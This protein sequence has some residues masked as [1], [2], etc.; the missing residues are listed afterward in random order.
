MSE[1]V[2]TEKIE[3]IF[4]RLDA[5]ILQ[6]QQEGVPLE[7]AFSLYE[8]GMRD[9]KLC[10]AQLDEIEKKMQILTVNNNGNEDENEV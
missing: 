5:T 10:A 7:E 6:M 4:K 8:Q 9:L 3:D 2:K 1:S